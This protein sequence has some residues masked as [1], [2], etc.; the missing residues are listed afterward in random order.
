MLF[1]FLVARLVPTVFLRVSNNG[2]MWKLS[3][4]LNQKEQEKLV[5]EVENHSHYFTLHQVALF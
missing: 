1:F 5:V 2:F 3:N 4:W